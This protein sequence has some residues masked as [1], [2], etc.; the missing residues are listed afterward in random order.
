[1]NLTENDLINSIH[2]HLNLPKRRSA[3]I[4]E[5]LLDI[6]RDTIESGEDILISGLGKFCVRDKHERMGRNPATGEDKMIRKRRVVTFMCSRRL[7]D[8]INKEG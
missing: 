8:E 5:S 3:A 2:N 4:V 7:R 1:M 6:I